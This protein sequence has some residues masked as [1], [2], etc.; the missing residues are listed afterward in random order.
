M[1]AG[2]SMDCAMTKDC[3][4]GR[5][6][7]APTVQESGSDAVEQA[8][9][10]EQHVTA[11]LANVTGARFNRFRQ[12]EDSRLFP[13]QLNKRIETTKCAVFGREDFPSP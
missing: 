12:P 3:T 4:G 11:R 10:F 1:G 2:S 8:A 6:E 9:E 7:H 5:S 13:A